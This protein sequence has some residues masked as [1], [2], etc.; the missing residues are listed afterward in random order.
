MPKCLTTSTEAN[1]I[2][3][4]TIDLAHNLGLSV[5]AEGVEDTEALAQLMAFGA[6]TAQGYLF[7][8]PMPAD[9]FIRMVQ[10]PPDFTNLEGNT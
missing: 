6:E 5:C 2:V 4:S 8:R 3:R 9:D 7:A 1:I 10:Q